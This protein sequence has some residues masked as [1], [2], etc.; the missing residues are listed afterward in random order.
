M[1]IMEKLYELHLKRNIKRSVEW[2]QVF[3]H[4]IQ[5]KSN[6]IELYTHLSKV[7]DLNYKFQERELRTWRIMFHAIGCTNITPYNKNISCI[8]IK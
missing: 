2:Y 4:W 5:Q 8:S 3:Q 6:V 1:I 7:Y